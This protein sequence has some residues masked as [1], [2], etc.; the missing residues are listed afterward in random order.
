MLSD[1]VEARGASGCE[2]GRIDREVA[3]A[4]SIQIQWKDGHQRRTV[5][6]Q[7][8]NRGDKSE[9][10]PDFVQGDTLEIHSDNAVRSCRNRS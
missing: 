3:I 7:S 6:I 5:I 1:R 8:V 10:M 2:V 4:E 9:R